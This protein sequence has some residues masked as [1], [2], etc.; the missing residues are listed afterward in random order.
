MFEFHLLD[1]TFTGGLVAGLANAFDGS[2]SSTIE[3]QAR[4][5]VWQPIKIE[6]KILMGEVK[7]LTLNRR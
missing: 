3:K 6:K 5:R 7:G 2:V 1:L 4:A